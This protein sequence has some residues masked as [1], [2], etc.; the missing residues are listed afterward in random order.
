MERLRQNHLGGFFKVLKPGPRH[1]PVTAVPAAGPG[2]LHFARAAR[3]VS[4]ARS[5][6]GSANRGFCRLCGGGAPRVLVRGI[7]LRRPTAYV[8]VPRP[9]PAGGD[10]VRPRSPE[11]EVCTCFQNLTTF[12]PRRTPFW[13]VILRATKRRSPPW[14]LVPM[15][16]NLVSFFF[17]FFFFF[18][19]RQTLY[20]SRTLP[21]VKPPGD[22]PRTNVGVEGDR[23]LGEPGAAGY[24]ESQSG[25]EPGPP[26]SHRSRTA[27]LSRTAFSW[28]WAGR[29]VSRTNH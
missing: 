9:D 10:S 23:R 21:L 3:E 2:N 29:Q 22:S 17:F 25:P 19:D 5:I 14:T 20:W 26:W 1:A 8:A 28:A 24:S 27:I 4:Q 13:S 11:F 15:A 7:L 16:N 6:L 18:G 12:L